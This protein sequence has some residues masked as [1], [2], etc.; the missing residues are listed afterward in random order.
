MYKTKIYTVYNLHKS[1]GAGWLGF[2]A[3]RG[4]YCLLHNHQKDA[5]IATPAN[6]GYIPNRNECLQQG[7]N[8]RLVMT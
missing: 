4:W 2:V 7:V 6:I 8:M 5:Y 3:E 1:S